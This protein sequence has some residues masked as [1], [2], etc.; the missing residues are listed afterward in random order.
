M[1]GQ[2]DVILDPGTEWFGI[3]G[4]FG[5]EEKWEGYC[6]LLRARGSIRGL[7]AS[8]ANGRQTLKAAKGQAVQTVGSR[9][10][11]MQRMED[12]T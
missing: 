8:D 4:V 2:I 3:D 5:E 11:R 12:R 7:V 9:E 1:E 6:G 10:G